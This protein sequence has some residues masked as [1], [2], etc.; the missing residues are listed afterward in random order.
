[1]TEAPYSASVRPIEGP[2]MMR[3]SSRTRIPDRGCEVLFK[4]QRKF[5]GVKGAGGDR[6]S[7]ELTVH[8]GKERRAFP[9]AKI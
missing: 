7:R 9:L 6:A 3:Q 1:M 5:V 8:G 4:V 2:A